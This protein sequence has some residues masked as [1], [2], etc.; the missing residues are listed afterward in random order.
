MVSFCFIRAVVLATTSAFLVNAHTQLY[1]FDVEGGSLTKNAHMLVTNMGNAPLRLTTLND[2]ELRCRSKSTDTTGITPLTVAAGSTL[3]FKYYHAHTVANSHEVLPSSH[4]GPCTVHLAL[5]SSNGE[6]DVWFKIFEESYDPKTKEWCAIKARNNQGIFSIK[7]PTDIKPETYII[8][9]ELI[10][11]HQGASTG[12][13]LYPNCGLITITG[14]GKLEPK[15]YPIPGIYSSTDVGLNM[16]RKDFT[17]PYP[18][19]GAPMYNAKS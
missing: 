1:A 16:D 2:N 7:I 5:A 4:S 9:S 17:T 3:S 15:G 6:G 18:I 12:A 13:Q 14:T 8:R 11:L 19:P 10:A